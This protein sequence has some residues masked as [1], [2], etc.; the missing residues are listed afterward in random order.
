MKT[1]L[2]VLFLTLS[3]ALHVLLDLRNLESQ[4]ILKIPYFCNSKSPFI[5]KGTRVLLTFLEAWR[6]LHC[7][8]GTIFFPQ[9]T[10]V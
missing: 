8:K 3:S 7:V 2:L 9:S 5:L 6:N 4:K 10:I 1:V